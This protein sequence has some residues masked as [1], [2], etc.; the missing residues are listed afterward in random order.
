MK[1]KIYLLIINMP[2]NSFWSSDDKIP[3]SQTKISIPSENGLSYDGGQRI[4]FTIPA[5]TVEYFN[6]INTILE[7]DFKYALDTNV[8]RTLLQLDPQLGGSVLIKHIRIYANSAEM[9]LLEEVQNANVL[10]ALRYD[11]DANDNIK[12][13]RALTEGCGLYDPRHRSQFKNEQTMGCNTKNN[14]YFSP[15]ISGSTKLFGDDN[16]DESTAACIR[17]AKLCLPLHQSGIFGS[18]V[19]FPNLMVN[20]LR[21]EIILEDAGKCLKQVEKVQHD[22]RLENGW[23][24]HSVDGNDN[25]DGVWANDKTKT[26][27]AFFISRINNA[28]EVSDCPFCVGEGFSFQQNSAVPADC[29]N[30]RM[31]WRKA[32]EATHFPIITNIQTINA[33]AANNTYALVKITLDENVY[34]DWGGAKAGTPQMTSKTENTKNRWV[35]YSTSLNHSAGE[36]L[37]TKSPASWE[38]TYTVSNV[39]LTV[40]KVEMPPAYTSKLASQMKQGGTI[41]YD[42]LSFTNY[43]YSQMKDDRV[44][45]IRI[46]IMNKRCKGVLCIPTDGS[47]YPNNQIVNCGDGDETIANQATRKYTYFTHREGNEMSAAVEGNWANYTERSGLVGIA[48]GLTNYQFFY[49]GRLNPSRKVDC[50]KISNRTSISQQPL[51]ELE[52]SLSVCGIPP[53]SFS[54]YRDNFCVGR[55]VGI[56]QGVADLSTTDFNLQCEYNEATNAPTKNKLWNIYIGHLRRLMIKG[57]SVMIDV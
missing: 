14:T 49:D 7:M 19:V 23:Y 1:I 9:P 40:E 57:D 42:F 16:T 55:A 6:P 37:N 15:N 18:S 22:N 54:K 2:T 11:Y 51:V 21:L 29:L 43:L 41:N 50:K 39:R 20:G 56:Q 25:L 48:D 46:P 17:T 32:D 3:I 38:P 5:G 10:A 8:N 28:L 35:M 34:P 26:K 27:N 44:A 52:K 30:K 13:K 33:G 45:N 4:I 12:K 36:A 47:V 53:N 31:T 24:F